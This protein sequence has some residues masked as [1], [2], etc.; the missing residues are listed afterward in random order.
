MKVRISPV[1]MVARRSAAPTTRAMKSRVR[2]VRSRCWRTC[3]LLSAMSLE[4]R[5]AGTVLTLGSF[6]S[7][8]FR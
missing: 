4:P 5:P 3:A 6:S 2:L 1:E 7:S 8:M